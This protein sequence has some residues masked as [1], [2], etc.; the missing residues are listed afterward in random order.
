M[1]NDFHAKTLA[2]PDSVLV[3]GNWQSAR[4]EPALRAFMPYLAIPDE[5]DRDVAGYLLGAERRAEGQETWESFVAAARQGVLYSV[6]HEEQPGRFAFDKPFR[7]SLLVEWQVSETRRREWRRVNQILC[8]YYRARWQEL[9]A[10]LSL[11]RPEETPVENVE[12]QLWEL[13][14]R[15]LTHH[16]AYDPLT[17]FERFEQVFQENEWLR[18][19]E[20]CQA[21]CAIAERFRATLSTK[22]RLWLDYYRAQLAGIRSSTARY[23]RLQAEHWRVTQESALLELLSTLESSPLAAPDRSE[24]AGWIYMQ[25]GQAALHQVPLRPGRTSVDEPLLRSALDCFTRAAEQF[26][27]MGSLRDELAATNNI[28]LV[29]QQAG[30]EEKAITEYESAIRRLTGREP[31]QLQVLASLL[32]NLGSALEDLG[33]RTS[34]STHTSDAERSY[35]KAA[36]VFHLIAFS[37]GRGVALLNLGRCLLLQGKLEKAERS[38][39]QALTVLAAIDAPEAEIA[40]TWLLWLRSSIDLRREYLQE[41]ISELENSNPLLTLLLVA[42]SGSFLM[43]SRYTYERVFGWGKRTEWATFVD[44]S[45]PYDAL[46]TG[47]SE[48]SLSRKFIS[49]LRIRRSEAFKANFADVMDRAWSTFRQGYFRSAALQFGQA[50][51]F[52]RAAGETNAITEALSGQAQ[53]WVRAGEPQLALESATRLLERARENP[54]TTWQIQAGLWLSS[55]LAMVDLR[56]R[57]T[58]IRPLL[59]NGLESVWQSEDMAGQVRH[60][61]GL[62]GYE[63]KLGLWEEGYKE[64]HRALDLLDSI[65]DE[66]NFS[67]VE[68]FRSLSTLM[69]G[70]G[71]LAEARRYAE[72]ALGSAR[73][74]EDANPA[75]VAGAQL[76]LAQ[77]LH[78]SRDTNKALQLA[79]EVLASSQR[80]EWTAHEQQA[81][82]LRADVLLAIGRFNDACQAAAR[83]LELARAMPA[84]EAEVEA[85]LSLGQALL[86]GGS[87]QEGRYTLGT[88]RSLSDERHYSERRAQAEVLLEKVANTGA[89]R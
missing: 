25:L 61:V 78:A 21:L 51:M 55:A 23:D 87:V 14:E 69:L 2:R 83:A 88:A 38:L 29:Y 80:Y 20:L 11:D 82:Q 43:L 57:W 46:T 26:A 42:G 49:S 7:D 58:E 13:I 1:I 8:E 53:A 77:I 50:A 22:H 3:P 37:Y 17:A 56:N 39:E 35:E 66:Q 4:L 15:E 45:K 9:T 59:L 72:L 16:F 28:G 67:R 63:V 12:A 24:L 79:D 76:T 65:V 62:G 40:G 33:H 75:C 74:V 70:K 60:L 54:E 31:G 73:D 47:L 30:L 19:A 32:L 71:N 44:S 81:Q 5:F 41:G 27:Q 18:A 36:D 52:G 89:I 34:S 6:V 68:T 84:L 85:L 48:F 64:L 86:A 10:T